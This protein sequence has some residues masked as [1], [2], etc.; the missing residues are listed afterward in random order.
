MTKNWLMPKGVD[1]CFE[2]YLIKVFYWKF[3]ISLCMQNVIA[4]SVL[5][6]NEIK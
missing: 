1:T 5:K 3:N 6:I 2:G 4:K